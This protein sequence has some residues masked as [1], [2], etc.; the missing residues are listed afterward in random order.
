MTAAD[1]GRRDNPEP[2]TTVT[3]TVA[4]FDP[5]DRDLEWLASLAPDEGM[6]VPESTDVAE[7]MLRIRRRL[8]ADVAE[9]NHRF[10][11]VIAQI[12]A[13]ADE[14]I[15]LVEGRR[16]DLVAGAVRQIANLTDALT[17]FARQHRELTKATKI[18]LPHGR[19]Q[20]RAGRSKIEIGDDVEEKL[21]AGFTPD[22]T[23][24]AQIL[25]HVP[26]QWKISKSK[27][28]ALVKA[29]GARFGVELVDEVDEQTGEIMTVA[30]SALV[31]DPGPDDADAD[32][33][34]KAGATLITGISEIAGDV[35]VTIEDP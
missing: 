8:L 4:D 32:A 35:N 30:L 29:G 27:I 14:E 12:Q 21:L 5:F 24:V 6:P 7:K 9:I 19:L 31:I 18:D 16:Q 10:E 17:G 2:S 15:D 1:V 11:P 3:D 22:Q 33:D 25:D 13:R 20:T 34:G 28:A 26:E 23:T